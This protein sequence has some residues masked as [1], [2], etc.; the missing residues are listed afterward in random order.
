MTASYPILRTKKG[1]PAKPYV[2]RGVPIESVT[3]RLSPPTC[4]LKKGLVFELT[5]VYR[6]DG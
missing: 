5:V 1:M 2:A 3:A 4:R 6:G